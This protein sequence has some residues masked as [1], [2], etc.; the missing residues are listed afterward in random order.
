MEWVSV[1]DGLPPEHMDVLVS[2]GF[3]IAEANHT[4]FGA[5]GIEWFYRFDGCGGVM[6]HITHWMP[7][8]ELPEAE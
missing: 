7:R 4:S 5:C 8:P 2:D 1:N 6:G 3:D